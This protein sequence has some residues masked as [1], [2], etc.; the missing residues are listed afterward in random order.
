MKPLFYNCRF[1]HVFLLCVCAVFVSCASNRSATQRPGR[2]V[3]AQTPK[4]NLK[5]PAAKQTDAS[6]SK[7]SGNVPVQTTAGQQTSTASQTAPTPAPQ[8]TIAQHEA[9]RPISQSTAS[10][11]YITRFQA[12]AVSEMQAFG[13]PASITLAQGLLESGSGNSYLAVTGNNHFGIKC[14]SDWQGPSVLYDD[15]NKNDCFRAYGNAED[16]FRDHSQFLLR[17]RYAA[18]FELNKDDYVGWARGLKKAGYATNPQ[19]ADLLISLIERY[20]LQ[21]YDIPEATAQDK[22]KREERILNDI[23][24]TPPQQEADYVN[25][26]PPLSMEIHEVSKGDTLY[27]IAKRYNLTVD[28]LKRKNGLQE[29]RLTI[30]QLL[31]VSK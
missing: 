3:F 11:D 19:Y 25:A 24:H 15:D 14:T 29:E 16:S 28:E 27:S 5:K 10:H 8:K 6:N 13:I 17:S 1:S 26:K 22:T 31:L 2:K 18:L 20:G 9:P 21:R 4:K 7:N 30:G 12:I 23:A